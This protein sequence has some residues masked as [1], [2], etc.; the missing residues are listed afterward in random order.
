MAAQITLAFSLTPSGQRFSRVKDKRNEAKRR[1]RQLC[2]CTNGGDGRLLFLAETSS[3]QNTIRLRRFSRLSPRELLFKQS[4][5]SFKPKRTLVQT[6]Q[7]FIETEKGLSS[8]KLKA[9]SC[10][11]EYLF[12][13]RKAPFKPKR[14]FVQTKES[15]I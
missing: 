15:P 5:A 6:K 11:K 10:R 4:K 9:H 12:K 2:N 14:A 1:N 7:N 8:G 13:Q 3:L